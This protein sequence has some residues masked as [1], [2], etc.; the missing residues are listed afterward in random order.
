[1]SIALPD[2]KAG[3]SHACGTLHSQLA[4][5]GTALRMIHMPFVMHK[6]N[7]L[8]LVAT[9]IFIG[10]TACRLVFVLQTV[11]AVRAL[12]DSTAWSC[13]GNNDD[14]ALAAWWQLQQG[15]PPLDPKHAWV[16][17]LLPDDVDFLMNMPFSIQVEG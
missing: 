8:A 10:G 5:H 1:M 16:D 9:S 12:C 4:V 7:L 14:G 17:Q 2:L 11:A 6:L 13:R 15:V 3:Q